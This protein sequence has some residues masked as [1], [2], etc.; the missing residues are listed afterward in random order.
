MYAK[1]KGYY[2]MNYHFYLE[3]RKYRLE[4]H[5]DVEVVAVVGHIYLIGDSNAILN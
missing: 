2:Y 4:E 5:S 3:N 1:T